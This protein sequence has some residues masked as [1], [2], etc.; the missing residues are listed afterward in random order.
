METFHYD[1]CKNLTKKRNS[2]SWQRCGEEGNPLFTA[3]IFT[4]VKTWKQP[5]HPSMH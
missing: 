5:K 2:K 3:D 4:V 1:G